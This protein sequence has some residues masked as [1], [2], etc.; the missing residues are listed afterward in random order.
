MTFRWPVRVY[1][2]DT[3]AGG[4][5]YYAN[6]FC[7][8]ERARSEWLRAIGYSQEALRHQNVLFVVREVQAKYRQPARLDDEL[9]V[10]VA[11]GGSRKV[12][13]L[14][15]QQVFRGDECL[16]TATIQIACM[17]LAG[18]PQAIPATLL[19]AM[20]ADHLTSESRSI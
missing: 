9:T 12:S 6:Y 3:D 10:T 16:L 5:V 19:N 8:L 2:E 18:R 14:L 20:T 13:L 17:N 1:I 7:F 11:V 4:I 15:E